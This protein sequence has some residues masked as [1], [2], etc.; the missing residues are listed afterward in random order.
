MLPH[1]NI[2]MGWEV[3]PHPPY[4]PDIAHLFRS[5]HFLSGKNCK[6]KF[7]LNTISR[8]FA[9]L[10][11]FYRSGIDNLHTRWKKIVDNE[12]TYIIGNVK[13]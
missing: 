13:N 2:E 9:Q 6:F 3:L 1:T 5:L 10:I 7:N 8:Y 12:D 4:L 11:Y